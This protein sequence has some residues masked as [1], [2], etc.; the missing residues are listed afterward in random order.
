[1]RGSVRRLIIGSAATIAL[2]AVAAAQAQATVTVTTGAATGVTAQSA[3]L[4]GSINTGGAAASWQFQYGTTTAYTFA[5]PIR[6]L[7]PGNATIPVA[8]VVSNLQPA[9][10]YHYRLVATTGAGTRYYP[11][12]TVAGVDLTFTTKAR[13]GGS[14]PGRGRLKLLSRKIAVKDQFAGVPLKCLSVKA[15]VGKLSLSLGATVTVK[16]HGKTHKHHAEIGCGT[17][18]Y[19]ILAGEKQTVRDKLSTA[20]TDLLRAARHHRLKSRLTT[21]PTSGQRGVVGLV[22]LHLE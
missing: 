7:A 5:T 1:M 18:R 8:A 6:Q 10:T 4:H 19:Q 13:A 12:V 2:T 17:A 16:K 15:C 20:C 9:T 22:T 21:K 3:V 11:L 14:R